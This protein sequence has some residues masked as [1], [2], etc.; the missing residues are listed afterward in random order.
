MPIHVLIVDDEDFIRELV[1]ETLAFEPYQVREAESGEA[2]LDS[3]SSAPPD[4]VLL[5]V[6]LGAGL[7]GFE[8]CQRIRQIHPDLPVIFLTGNAAQED[9]DAGAAAGGTAYL[10][11]PFSPIELIRS[12]QSLGL[13]S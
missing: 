11:K 13:D 2:G 5:D 3:I 4:V 9:R 6:D 8:T 12:M 1:T 7:S 10:C